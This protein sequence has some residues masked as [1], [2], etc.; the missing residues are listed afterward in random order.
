MNN[1]AK[2][3]RLIFTR[4]CLKNCDGCCMRDISQDAPR[5]I[6]IKQLINYQEICITGGEP[7][8]FHRELKDLIYC[9]KKE[10]RVHRRK[11]KI[12]LYTAMPYP[13]ISFIDILKELDGCTLT[14]HNDQ[15]K[16]EFFRSHLNFIERFPE[17]FLKS[18]WLNTF[19]S[20]SENEIALCAAW[21][22]RQKIWLKHCPLPEGEDLV[23]LK[24]LN[25]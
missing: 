7:L 16:W 5:E 2:K 14:L 15:D 23:R 18:L 20:F 4:T 21:K 1:T 9:I 12:I 25:I 22:I 24:G 10:S 13:V 17:S 19:V 11:P 3:A 6:N 8:C